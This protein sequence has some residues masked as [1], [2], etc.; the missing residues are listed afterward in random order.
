MLLFKLSSPPRHG[1]SV[2]SRKASLTD[3]TFT[4]AGEHVLQPFSGC[5]NLTPIIVVMRM[6][7]PAKSR[8]PGSRVSSAWRWGSNCSFICGLIS[9][10]VPLYAKTFKFS[11]EATLAIFLWRAWTSVLPPTS[12]SMVTLSNATKARRRSDKRSRNS[13]GISGSSGDASNAFIS[14]IRY[15]CMMFS[16][17]SEVWP[18]VVRI[19]FQSVAS[20]NG[21]PE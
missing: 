16:A 7:C 3:H 2:G 5:L 17:C 10:N 14:R 13:G 4:F 20:S 12:G 15:S 8:N 9:S 21:E 19:L 18:K 1:A 6:A 11:S